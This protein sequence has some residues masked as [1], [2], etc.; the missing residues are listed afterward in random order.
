VIE[1]GTSS[2]H[3]DLL[4]KLHTFL[5]TTGSA[6]GLVPKAGNTGNGGFGTTLKGGSASIAETWTVHLTSAS[7]FT[8]VGSVSGA[9]GGTRTV[10]SAFVSDSPANRL[11]FTLTAGGTDFVNG[12]E[13]TFSTA[14]KWTTKDRARGCTILASTVTSGQYAADNVI[15]GK[16]VPTQARGWNFAS[17]ALPASI[18]FTMQEA[19]TIREYAILS[20]Y[21]S[22][23]IITAWTFDYW[24]GSAWVTLDTVSG[25]SSWATS[26]ESFTVD[27]PVSATRYRLNIT[28]GGADMYVSA[29]QLR[30]VAGGLDAAFGQHLWMAPGNDGVSEIYVGVHHFRRTD[31][32]YYD[33]ELMAFDGYTAGL[34]AY[35]QTGVHRLLYLPLWN[36]TMNYWFVADGRRVI[37]VVKIGTQYEAAYLGLYDP[38]FTP[39]QLPYPICLGGS[40]AMQ[41]GAP[42]WND[43]KYKWSAVD[44]GHNL[45]MHSDRGSMAGVAYYYMTMRMR[46]LTGVWVGMISQAN[47]SREFMPSSDN[48]IWPYAGSF[49]ALDVDHDGGYSL[50]PIILLATDPN[51]MGQLSGVYAVTGQGAGAEDTVTVGGIPHLLIPNVN[52]TTVLDWF[53][54]RLD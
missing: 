53:A 26:L 23:F 41:A 20:T 7:A 11:A 29:V 51:P 2:G 17:A 3:L 50:F 35:A 6:F 32:D 10:G 44:I 21:A 19:E 38:F 37:I 24:N 18:E 40:R 4:E 1:T 12:D 33:W 49:T 27:S 30:R 54:L 45:F 15:D 22:S 39:A 52:R 16:T 14:P 47:G 25:K 8:V 36:S 5:T 9:Q 28:A 46:R 31:V 48:V 13:F 43:T 42:N 34:N